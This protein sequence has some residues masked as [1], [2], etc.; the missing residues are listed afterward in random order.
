MVSPHEKAPLRVLAGFVDVF[1]GEADVGDG[2]L[3][4]I[5]KKVLVCSCSEL[6]ARLRAVVFIR[7]PALG[8]RLY[9]EGIGLGVGPSWSK[10]A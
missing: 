6:A 9:F 2:N 8:H 4:L 3:L 5:W 10:K 1:V 7:Q